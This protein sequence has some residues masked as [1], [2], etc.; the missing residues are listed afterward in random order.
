MKKLV[1]VMEMDGNMVHTHV[2]GYNPAKEPAGFGKTP[3]ASLTN[4]IQDVEAQGYKFELKEVPERPII[5]LNVR[6]ANA[7]RMVEIRTLNAQRSRL[8]YERAKMEVDSNRL[9][10]Q[11]ALHQSEVMR[12]TFE[13]AEEALKEALAEQEDLQKE[14]K[15]PKGKK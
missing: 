4:F 15:G 9:D 10:V 11:Q 8:N 7:K 2:D 14:A 5:P 13:D 1:I 3:F 6:V 12:R